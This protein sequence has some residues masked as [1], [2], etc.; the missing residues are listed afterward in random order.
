MVIVAESSDFARLSFLQALLRD[1]GLSPM[2]YDSNMASMLGGAGVRPRIAV[3]KAQAA[4]AR[5]VLREAG[6]SCLS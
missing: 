1:A 6:E 3:P 5:R 4:Q 2:L